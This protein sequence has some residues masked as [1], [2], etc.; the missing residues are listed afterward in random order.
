MPSTALPGRLTLR[1]SA[2]KES[3]EPCFTNDM[4]LLNLFKKIRLNSEEEIVEAVDQYIESISFPL[5]SLQQHH[6]VIMELVTALFRFSVN[7]DIAAE[8]VG[9]DIGI[10]YG[11]LL[12]LEPDALRKWLTDISLCF[13]ENLITARSRSTQSFVSKARSMSAVNMQMYSCLWLRFVKDLGCLIPI[14]LQCLK[15]KQENLLSV[16]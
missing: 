16:M 11:K 9:G 6:V 4:E 14:F 5:K 15:R 1:K 12:E 3:G 8:G 7:N 13:S 10:L 2:P